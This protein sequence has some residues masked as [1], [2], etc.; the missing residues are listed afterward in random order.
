MT[1]GHS[2]LAGLRL[3]DL[4]ALRRQV[5]DRV[6][7]DE[8][9]RVRAN[10]DKIRARCETLSGFF[11]ESWSVLEPSARYVDNW[12]IGAI[13]EHLEAITAG[14]IKRLL[15][16]VPPGS[17]KSLAAS[18]MWPAWEW[19]PKGLRSM[20]YLTTSFNEIPVKRDTRKHRDLTLSAFYRELWPEV[21]LTRTGEMSFANSDTGNREGVPFGSLTSQRGDRLIIDDPHSTETAESDAERAN[22]SRKFREGALSRVNDEQESAILVIM[23]RLHQDDISG[24][25]EQFG[26]GFDRL[27]IPMEFEPDRRIYT[28]IGWTD[29]RTE[30][31]ELM[32]PER[33]P[34]NVCEA[35]KR[36]QG[37]YVWAGQYQQRPA[38]REGGMF[39]VD[40]I[41]IVDY[42][43]IGGKMI[44]GWD[45]AGSKKKNSPYTVGVKL[46][47]VD[48][49]I[50]VLDVARTRKEV[51]EMP[52]YIETVAKAD[53]LDVLQDYPQ[54]PGVGGKALKA[55]LADKLSGLDFVSSVESGDKVQRAIPISAQVDAG[56]MR[57][58]RAPWNAAFID[59]L[60]NFPASSFKDQ[61]DALSR[62]YTRLVSIKTEEL[63]EAPE[64][65]SPS[66]GGG[67]DPEMDGEDYGD[68][69][70]DP[71]DRDY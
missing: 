70:A 23:Q 69:D 32:F 51:Q 38:P 37:A 10:A 48:G 67:H 33:F 19:G 4:L 39:Q 59:E 30:D 27:I 65:P 31:G 12:H 53:G 18:V 61:V 42:A 11:T 9:D 2:A 66:S 41:G 47:K 17:M 6:A 25:I 21:V 71:W 35:K 24:V 62:A 26:M 5:A 60:R 56:M 22:T 43:P 40:K 46:K 49:L 34:R 52:A 55:S 8:M 63:G 45:L 50:Y 58:V 16:N 54:D 14:Q 20:R 44:R 3:S 57:L 64:A 7:A 36:D 1:T 15:I 29:P 28:S 68:D 13:A